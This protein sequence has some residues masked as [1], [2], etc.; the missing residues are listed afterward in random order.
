MRQASA[1]SKRTK[2]CALTNVDNVTQDQPNLRAL[3]TSVRPA[4]ASTAPHFLP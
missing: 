2:A 3:R 4:F 1:T